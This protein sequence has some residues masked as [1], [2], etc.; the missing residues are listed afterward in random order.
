MKKTSLVMTQIG[1]YIHIYSPGA[2]ENSIQFCLE[3][4][5]CLSDYFNL[6]KLY[7]FKFGVI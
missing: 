4:F 1:Y 5:K 6:L 3:F 7:L 2:L